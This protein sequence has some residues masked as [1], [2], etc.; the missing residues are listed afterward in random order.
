MLIQKPQPR[1]PRPG[2]TRFLT[3]SADITYTNDVATIEIDVPDDECLLILGMTFS[4]GAGGTTNIVREISQSG[5]IAL[6]RILADSSE[7]GV[8]LPAIAGS[9]AGISVT[10]S[11]GFGRRQ[12]WH[13]DPEAMKDILEAAAIRASN[14]PGPYQKGANP[15]EFYERMV[16]NV[17]GY[18]S[19]LACAGFVVGDSQ[20]AK[21]TIV[22]ERLNATDSVTNIT[23]HGISLGMNVDIDQANGQH[24]A[25]FWNVLQKTGI[26]ATAG[27]YN[28]TRS[29][30]LTTSMLDGLFVRALFAQYDD[31]AGVLQNRDLNRF[32]ASKFG[33][34]PGPPLVYGP[35]VDFGA[36]A[37]IT[38]QELEA[39]Y[40][41]VILNTNR[42]G[43]TIAQEAVGGSTGTLR[44]VQQC[45]GWKPSWLKL[46]SGKSRLSA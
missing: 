6:N 2:D 41:Q 39:R 19:T 46:L 3:H 31:G 9:A 45:F 16:K 1:V 10:Q 43:Y 8:P 22:L 23:L 11:S 30:Q 21:I 38:G 15:Q 27:P 7:I 28:L 13:G 20:N 32:T 12:P 5:A 33:D 40:E 29:M 24:N 34:W 36:L 44:I 26:L 18:S 37:Q 42:V 14:S 25:P 17:S 35:P 4:A